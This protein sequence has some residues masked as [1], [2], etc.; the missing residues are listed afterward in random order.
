MLG[1]QEEEEEKDDP[2]V[3]VL[4]ERICFQPLLFPPATLLYRAVPKTYVLKKDSVAGTKSA[5]PTKS[6]WRVYK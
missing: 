4:G 3:F 2:V 5:A 6:Y 1:H